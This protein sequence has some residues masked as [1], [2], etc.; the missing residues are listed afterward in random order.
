MKLRVQVGEVSSRLHP[1]HPVPPL[2]EALDDAAQLIFG[3]V[4]DGR[5]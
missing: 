4:L 5:E 3:R 2:V 1:R